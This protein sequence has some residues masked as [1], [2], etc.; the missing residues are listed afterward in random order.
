[1]VRAFCLPAEDRNEQFTGLQE[2]NATNGMPILSLDNGNY[3]LFQHYSL[4][5]AIYES[6]FFW[7]IGDKAYAPTALSHRGDFAESLALGCLRR[8]FGQHV[9]AN[10]HVERSKGDERGEIDVLVA[11]GDRAI[12]LQAKSKRLTLEARKGNEAHVRADFKMA[13]QDAYDQALECSK[14]LIEGSCKLVDSRGEVIKLSMP[15]K[16]IFPV[17]I[18]SDHYPALAFQAKQFL[19]AVETEAIRA[20]LVTDAITE[21]LET[22]LRLL[23]YLML[24][25]KFGGRVSSTHEFTLLSMHLKHNLWINEK[26]D[27]VVLEDDISVHLDSAM[28]VR[29]EGL[30]GMRTPDGVLARMLGTPVGRIISDIE[31]RPDAATIPLGFLLLSLSENSIE[32]I[33][34]GIDLVRSEAASDGRNHDFTVLLG[35]FSSGVTIH[36]NDRPK[37]EAANALFNHCDLRKYSAKAHTWF[38]L[39]LSPETGLVR[40]GLTSDGEWKQ[41][42]RMDAASQHMPAPLSTE[43][44]RLALRGKRKV[45][46]NS[47]CP[48]GSGRKYKKCCGR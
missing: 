36:C 1:V 21:M 30:A 39:V 44:F 12:V 18:V 2:Y 8:V 42:D 20:P 32:T 27:F 37:N 28:M 7:M 6:P 11:F 23:S 17:C 46:R 35:E 14:A 41:D 29:R 4:L 13:V 47:P 16:E 19:K 43:E 33:N 9:H 15:I 25:S 5:E 31:S 34:K 48:C 26:Y 3:V 45:G 10:V 24:R 38:G 22:P 40:F